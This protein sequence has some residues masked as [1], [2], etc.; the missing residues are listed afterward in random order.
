MRDEGSSLIELSVVLAVIGLLVAATAYSYQG[1]IGKYRVEKATCEL[2]TDLMQAR[3]KAMQTNRDHFAVLDAT[4]YSIVEDTNENGDRDGGDNVL[5]SFPKSLDHVLCKN[6]TGNTLTF[7]RRG[8]I[9]QIRT[10]WFTSSA[11]PGL[12]CMKVSRSRIIVGR[13]E[14]GECRIR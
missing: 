5:P 12:D 7:E 2:Y 4:S 3:L 10:L 11:D 8:M 6:G 13:Y 1:W 9:S 14:G